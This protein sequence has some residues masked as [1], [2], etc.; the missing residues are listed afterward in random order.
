VHFDLKADNLLVNLTAPDMTPE[1][2]IGDLGL[3]KV[4]QQ[5]IMTGEQ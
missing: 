5:S 4:K 2:K 3:V 1:V